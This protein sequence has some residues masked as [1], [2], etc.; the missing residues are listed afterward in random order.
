MK[1]KNWFIIPK[2]Y[3]WIVIVNYDCELGRRNDPISL[4]TTYNLARKS[5]KRT[6]YDTF[7]C[8]YSIDDWQIRPTRH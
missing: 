8:I 7:L 1:R 2:R 4:H 3:K 6:G 5:A